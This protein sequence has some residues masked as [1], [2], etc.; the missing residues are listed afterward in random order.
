M[1]RHPE[2]GSI[3]CAPQKV[4]A[5][6]DECAAEWVEFNNLAPVCIA[7]GKPCLSTHTR[8]RQVVMIIG[9][10]PRSRTV[11][12]G[13][14]GDAHSRHQLCIHLAGHPIELLIKDDRVVARRR[15]D[16]R[17]HDMHMVWCADKGGIRHKAC[18]RE[19]E[20][21]SNRQHCHYHMTTRRF[22]PPFCIV[23][24]WSLDALDSERVP[25][26]IRTRSYLL[27]PTSPGAPHP[28]STSLP[29]DVTPHPLV[30]FRLQRGGGRA[31]RLGRRL[32]LRP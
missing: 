2:R 22:R 1:Q 7:T 3:G 14:R 23:V 21:E 18:Q 9:C 29:T 24:S 26:R 32:R 8:E 4:L 28:V 17:D 5:T 19:A 11:Y 27:W 20:H 30:R 13:V 31:R 12:F 15:L 6:P 10:K 25:R 16:A